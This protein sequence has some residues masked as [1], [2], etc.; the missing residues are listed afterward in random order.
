MTAFSSTRVFVACLLPDEAKAQFSERFDARFNAHGRTLTADELVADS[1]GAEALVVTATD[2]LDAATIARLPASVRLLATY[3][4][5]HEHIDTPAARERGLTVLYTPDVLS[6]AC[7]D[8]ALLLMLGAAR[9]VVESQALVR[10]GAWTGWTALQLLGRD[11]HGARLGILGMGRIGRAVAKRARGFD[12]VVHYH[13]RSRLS[14]EH[15]AGALYHPTLDTLLVESDFLCVA[16]PSSPETRH[17]IDAARIARLPP[18][19]IIVNIARGEVIDDQALIP[20]LESGRIFAAGL[21]V[22]E[23]EPNIA[24]AYRTLPNVFSLP[25]IGS[26]T[27]ETRV[28]MA[29][30]LAHGITAAFAGEPVPNRLA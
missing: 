28:A 7:A 27:L 19:A 13:N 1:A 20:A 18:G 12:M 29:R 10:S 8:T 2:R 15:E 5:G 17:L 23:G 16:C 24:P 3:S 6:D 22:F 11:V 9:R 4:V 21:D 26:S 14:P 30:L 25:H